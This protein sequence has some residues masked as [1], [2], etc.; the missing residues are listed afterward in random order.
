MQT[1]RE[2]VLLIS[3]MPLLTTDAV[4]QEQV[5]VDVTSIFRTAMEEIG[6]PQG[7]YQ[8]YA[9][10]SYYVQLLIKSAKMN[11]EDIAAAIRTYQLVGESIPT[12]D[13]KFDRGSA[14][15]ILPELE[16]KYQK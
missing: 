1:R 5:D 8:N 10:L 13:A 7:V 3:A 4:A 15:K 12:N 11:R 9:D 6:S 14:E 16:E 2:T